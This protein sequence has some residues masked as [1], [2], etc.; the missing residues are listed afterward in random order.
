MA[1]V[2]VQAAYVQAVD[3]TGKPVM[4]VQ[5]TP[6]QAQVVA[7]G[8]GGGGAM[9]VN[10]FQNLANASSLEFK[11]GNVF[12]E[13]VSGGCA[14]N[15]YMIRDRLSADAHG[16]MTPVFIASEESSC[17]CRAC[18]DPNQPAYVKFYN[19][20]NGGE[21]PAKKCCGL[22]I[23]EA[24]TLY[25]KSGGAVMT[26]EKPGCWKNCAQMG[27]VNCFVCCSI[28]QSEAFMHTGEI[29]SRYD[30]QGCGPCKVEHWSF[31]KVDQALHLKIVFFHMR[32]YQFLVVGVHQLLIL[33]HVMVKWKVQHH[34]RLLLLKVQHVLVAVWIY[35]A[36][37]NCMYLSICFSYLT[38]YILTPCFFTLPLFSLSFLQLN[39]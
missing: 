25:T 34:R 6:A 14:A 9:D 2:Q 22:T 16:K 15:S 7:V 33:W 35:A 27:A 12:W 23:S 36:I 20:A 30:P 11:Q 5:Q 38:L 19:V 31:L 18:C 21:K 37:Q 39:E 26:L 3:A 8:G 17:W 24:K 29:E 13:A 1:A 4:A 10:A 28:C 32:K